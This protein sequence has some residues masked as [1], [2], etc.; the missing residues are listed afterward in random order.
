MPSHLSFIGGR[1]HSTSKLLLDVFV[2]CL[3]MHMLAVHILFCLVLML[4]LVA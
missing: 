4:R 3:L 1:L 2:R